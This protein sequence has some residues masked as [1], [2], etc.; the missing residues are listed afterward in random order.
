MDSQLKD[1][2]EQDLHTH[3]GD[4]FFEQLS[5]GNNIRMI[6]KGQSMFPFLRKGDTVTVKPILF[7]ET[8]IGDIIA[9]KREQSDKAL[10]LHRLMKK[11]QTFIVTKGDANRHGD[12]PVFTEQICGKAIK[13]ERGEKTKN[14]ETSFQPLLSYVIAHTLW[15]FAASKDFLSNPVHFFKTRILNRLDED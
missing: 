6:V 8:R 13:I 4:I 14:L 10:T 15:G 2:K 3:V 7:K 5:Q 1:N 11:K 12:P 9:F